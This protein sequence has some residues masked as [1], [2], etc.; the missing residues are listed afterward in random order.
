[1]TENIN[2]ENLKK[3]SLIVVPYGLYVAGDLVQTGIEIGIKANEKDGFT[4]IRYNDEIDKIIQKIK[5]AKEKSKK[6]P[7]PLPENV[8]CN[9]SFQIYRG[10]E[11]E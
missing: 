5:D 7:D 1:M 4:I 6:L 8:L 10:K 2:I 3:E 11:Y 9:G